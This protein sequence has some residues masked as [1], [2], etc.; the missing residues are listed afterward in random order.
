LP[1]TVSAFEFTLDSCPENQTLSGWL[2]G[3]LRSAILEGRL[4]QGA[5]LPAS[6]DF[7][8]QYGLSRGTVV[9]VFERLQDEGYV[10]S[11]VG[12]GTLVNR[13]TVIRPARQMSAASPAY[14]RRAISTHK[15]P[16]PWVDLPFTKGIRPFRIGNPAT[17]EF[18]S[19]VWGQISARYARN[20]SSW[21]KTE[22]D[23]GGYRPLRDAVADYLRATRGVRCSAEQIVIVSG[24]QQALDL[25]ARMLLKEHDQ[26]WMED[27]GYFGATIAFGNVGA[28]IVPVP[29]DEDGLVVSAGE[30]ICPHARGVYLTPA[31]QFPLGV[32]MSLERRMAVL[33]WAKRTGAFVIEDDYDSEYR[34]EGTPVPSLQSLDNYSNVILIGSF[35]K[36]LFQSLRLGYIVLPPALVDCFLAFRHRTDFRN[37]SVD[38]A[39]LCEFIVEGHLAR[40]L[41]RMRQLYGGRLAAL[42]DGGKQH[43]SGVL[44]ISNVRAGLYTIGFLT[45]GM[46]SRQAEKLA[47]DQGVEVLGVD[48]YTFKRPD[49]KAL[50]LGFAGYP[51]PAI[52]KALM[53]L[54]R[55]FS[56]RTA[57]GEVEQARARSS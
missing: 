46:S 20:F 56:R 14:I 16:R 5:R 12:F 27:P 38:Q 26:V 8:G 22:A 1:K 21:L 30:K 15:P 4:A 42:I 10:T 28:E 29:V 2:Y 35:T 55:A 39:V 37:T 6:R 53:Q 24:A 41:R 25:L 19:K 7:A 52:E 23:R 17:N 40:H 3:E 36:T 51:E 9:S 45:N 18:P 44:E 50:V 43:L 32:T 49:P 54:A 57:G 33:K 34:F 11:R 48:R 31:H 47:A 13:V